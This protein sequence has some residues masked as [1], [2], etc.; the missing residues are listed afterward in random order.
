MIS[1]SFINHPLQEWDL[2]TE[3]KAVMEAMNR[4]RRWVPTERQEDVQRC[5]MAIGALFLTV[6]VACNLTGTKQP[7]E[8]L[9]SLGS[10]MAVLSDVPRRRWWLS[11][12]ARLRIDAP[13]VCHLDR[14]FVR[15]G[16]GA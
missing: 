2:A 11:Q 15:L 9:E 7:W 16:T 10:P 14:L 13:L 4:I 12:F 8:L 3:R 6:D 1:Q 5:D